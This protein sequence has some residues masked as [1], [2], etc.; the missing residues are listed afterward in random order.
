MLD[1]PR[2]MTYV[3]GGISHHEMCSI[4]DLQSTVPAQIVPGSNEIVTPKTF[5][6]Q[7]E[8]LHKVDIKKILRG[9]VAELDNLQFLGIQSIDNLEETNIFDEDEM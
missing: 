2:I 1:N 7:M 5:L 8:N 9:D 6:K 3:V 4:A